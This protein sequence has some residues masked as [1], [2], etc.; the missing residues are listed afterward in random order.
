MTQKQPRTHRHHGAAILA[1]GM[2]LMLGTIVSEAPQNTLSAHLNHD[3][4]EVIC[5]DSVSKEVIDRFPY[6]DVVSENENHAYNPMDA[7][8]QRAQSNTRV[9]EELL[10]LD[11]VEQAE[12]MHAAP[13]AQANVKTQIVS[14]VARW[15]VL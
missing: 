5:V 1:T 13:S 15:F 10:A 3:K 14:E 6:S 12:S 9:L 8:V 2:F 4:R 7:V 11:A